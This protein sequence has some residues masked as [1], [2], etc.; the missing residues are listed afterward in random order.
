[1]FLSIILEWLFEKYATQ[2]SSVYEFGCGTGHHLLRLRALNHSAKLYGLDWAEA[3]QKIIEEMVAKGIAKDIVG[4]KFDFFNPDESFV[5]DDNSVAYTVGALEQVGSNH[6]K[7][8]EYLIK[9]K[10]RVCFHVEPVGELLDDTNLLDYLTKEYYK[11]RNYL[12]N[13]IGHLTTL[14]KEGKIVIQKAMR[15]YMSGSLLTEYV[16]VVWAPIV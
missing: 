3:S 16:V 1:M 4:R 14:E 8:I 15:T 12:S 9:N 6:E 2:A 5:L 10:P 13:F 11:K 7:F